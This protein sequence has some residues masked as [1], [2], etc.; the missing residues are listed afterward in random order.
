M[1]LISFWQPSSVEVLIITGNFN[2]DY[3]D[4]QNTCIAH[5]ITIIQG[6]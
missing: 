1:K 5:N 3:C 2:D 4:N 6:V